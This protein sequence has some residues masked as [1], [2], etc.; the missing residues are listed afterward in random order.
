MQTRLF[1]IGT[2][3]TSNQMVKCP[4]SGPERTW[5][6]QRRHQDSNHDAQHKSGGLGSW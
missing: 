6:L 1:V 5:P 2:Q 4:L 3:Q